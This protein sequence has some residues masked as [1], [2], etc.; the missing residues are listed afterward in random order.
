[1]HRQCFV[2]RWGSRARWGQPRELSTPGW[3]TYSLSPLCSGSEPALGMHVG[4]PQLLLTF[5][6]LPKQLQPQLLCDL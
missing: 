1:M 6:L 3:V 2:P 5:S 4:K